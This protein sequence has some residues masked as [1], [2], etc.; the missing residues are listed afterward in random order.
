MQGVVPTTS[1]NGVCHIELIVFD[2]SVFLLII[3]QCLAQ[4]KDS[5]NLTSY[6]Y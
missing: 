1:V 4:R 6:S 2:L 5:V 3:A